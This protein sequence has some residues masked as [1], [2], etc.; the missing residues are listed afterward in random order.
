M[1]CSNSNNGEQIS[2]NDNLEPGF[3][4]DSPR[5]N[6]NERILI[7]EEWNPE[8]IY[9]TWQLSSAL[10]AENLKMSSC[11][12]TQEITFTKTKTGKQSGNDHFAMEIAQNTEN[13]PEIKRK[14]VWYYNPFKER[15]VI[16]IN[17]PF[18]G[19]FVSGSFKVTG[20]N[21]TSMT[22]TKDFYQINFTRLKD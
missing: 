10:T 1:N 3:K 15:E 6:L 12:Q 22:L 21:S 16:L 20:L 11:D 17:L 5:N 8:L 18:A 9:T 2:K 13:C 7:P 14:T 4:I 19:Q